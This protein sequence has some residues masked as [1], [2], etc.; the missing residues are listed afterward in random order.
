MRAFLYQVQAVIS[1]KN[2]EDGWILK[3][4]LSKKLKEQLGIRSRHN[5][6]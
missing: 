3:I 5:F 2:G 4:R 6:N 1:E